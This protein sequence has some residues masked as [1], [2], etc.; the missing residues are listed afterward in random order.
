MEID[1]QD[2][3]ARAPL[4]PNFGRCGAAGTALV[5]L[6]DAAAAAWHVCLVSWFE[7]V[8]FWQYVAPSESRGLLRYADELG[9]QLQEWCAFLRLLDEGVDDAALLALLVPSSS[10]PAVDNSSIWA[11]SI[12]LCAL[13]TAATATLAA[14]THCLPAPRQ[15]MTLRR[16]FSTGCISMA[17]IAVYE[18]FFF[19]L[20]VQKFKPRASAGLVDRV[21]RQCLLSADAP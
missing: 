1:Y 5:L 17:A 2:D 10:A 14:W 20:V 13:T 3:D 11:L 6:H 15:K 16:I 7:T 19:V 9:R 12:V 21:A 8:F 18:F 4:R